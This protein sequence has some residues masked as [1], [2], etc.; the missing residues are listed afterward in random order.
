[1]HPTEKRTLLFTLSYNGK[2][3]PVQAV[4][5]EYTS[6][7]RLIS[8]YLGIPGFGLCSGM[9]SCGTCMVTITGKGRH[10]GSSTL[11]CAT[12]VDDELANAVVM[13]T[14]GYY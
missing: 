7:M 10:K 1:M 4:R 8:G 9:G 14:D 2:Q 3:Y 12:P 6:L 13:I 5:K 11:S